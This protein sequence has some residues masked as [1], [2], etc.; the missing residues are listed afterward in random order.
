MFAPVANDP[1][2][3]FPN[4]LSVTD[5]VI[6]EFDQWTHTDRPGIKALAGCT[7]TWTMSDAFDLAMR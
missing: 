7:G 4:E 3:E 5:L 1:T 2:R 6:L